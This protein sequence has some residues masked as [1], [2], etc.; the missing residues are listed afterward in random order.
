VPIQ[1]GSAILADSLYLYGVD[2]MD[3]WHIKDY[4]RAFKDP[5]AVPIEAT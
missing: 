3:E 2:Y 1:H 4:F 5:F